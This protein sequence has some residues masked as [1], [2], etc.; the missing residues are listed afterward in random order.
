M[1]ERKRQSLRRLRFIFMQR[2]RNY[3]FEFCFLRSAQRFFM[4]SAIRLRP[5]GLSLRLRVDVVAGATAAAFLLPLGRPGPLRL[6]VEGTPDSSARACCSF[7]IWSS[8]SAMMRL[9]ST[10][11]LQLA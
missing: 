11:Y 8:I 4:A 3:P 9:T 10:C 7:D 5:S 1:K 6:A 2:S